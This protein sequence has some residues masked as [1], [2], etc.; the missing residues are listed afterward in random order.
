[1]GACLHATK[2]F[3]WNSSDTAVRELHQRWEDIYTRTENIDQEHYANVFTESQLS[4][5]VDFI[6]KKPS[7]F[8][9]KFPK[10]LRSLLDVIQKMGVSKYQRDADRMHLFPQRKLLSL[11]VILFATSTIYCLARFIIIALAF[12]SLRAMPEAVYETTWATVVPNVH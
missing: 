2:E 10:Q 11:C 3:A 1:M 4:K 7:E 9:K 12:T 5:L 6:E 8:P